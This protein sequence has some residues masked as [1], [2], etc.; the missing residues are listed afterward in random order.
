M[1]TCKN[2]GRPRNG[3]ENGNQTNSNIYHLSPN[4]YQRTNSDLPEIIISGFANNGQTNGQYPP[5]THSARRTHQKP[6]IS[7]E[8]ESYGHFSQVNTIMPNKYLII[9][10]II[11]Q[12]SLFDIIMFRVN[13]VALE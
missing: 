8:K 1:Q 7:S 12:I 4:E 13:F 9:N 3:N 5:G 2:Q 10:I 6:P 11:Y